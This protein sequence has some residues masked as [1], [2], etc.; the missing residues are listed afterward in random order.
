[1][2]IK[3]PEGDI[4]SNVLGE[5]ILKTKKISQI[6]RDKIVGE[7]PQ[8]RSN[9]IGKVNC[10]ALYLYVSLW[11]QFNSRLRQINNRCSELW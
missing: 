4:L 2:N 3:N 10:I 8:F 11:M 7:L 5:E 9:V 6:T 1:M